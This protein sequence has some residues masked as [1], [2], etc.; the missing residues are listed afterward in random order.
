MN[1]RLQHTMTFTAGVYYAGAIRMNN[2]IARFWMTTNSVD[3]ESHNIAFERIKHFVYSCID[4]TIFVNRSYTEK[5][6]KLVEAG[7]GITT[8]PDEPVDQVIG[9]MLHS[10]LNAI[11]EDRMIIVETE[12]SSDLGDNMVY[13]HGEG[14]NG[15]PLEQDGWWKDADLTHYDI[16][17]VDEGKLV[18][19]P[20]TSVWRDLDL[21]WPDETDQPSTDNTVIFDFQR[22]ETR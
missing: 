12:L 9:I 22:D 16:E 10:K 17:L 8:L 4:S 1:V 2:Y 3:G 18:S 7:V 19:V 20:H 13:L 15:G 5:C 14:E 6:R 11:M 21:S